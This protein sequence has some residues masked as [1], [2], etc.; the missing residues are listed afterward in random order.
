MVEPALRTMP[1]FSSSPRENG[2][3]RTTWG[4]VPFWTSGGTDK[5]SSRTGFTPRNVHP[6]NS[7]IMTLIKW[8]FSVLSFVNLSNQIKHQYATSNNAV[9]KNQAVLQK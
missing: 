8:M 2:Q 5:D 3:S 7:I 9:Y 6:I 4:T 1:R